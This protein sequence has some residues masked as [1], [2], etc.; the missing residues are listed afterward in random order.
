VVPLFWIEKL[1]RKK[2]TVRPEFIAVALTVTGSPGTTT[3]SSVLIASESFGTAVIG[4]LTVM[5][6]FGPQLGVPGVQEPPWH[7]S[8]VVQLFPSLHA[9]PSASVGFEQ[10]PVDV[11]QVPTAWHWSCAVHVTGLPPVQLP[12]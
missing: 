10:T 1:F 7:A 3:S 9:V 5:A 11:L 4:E 2:S 6:R 12:D 8:P